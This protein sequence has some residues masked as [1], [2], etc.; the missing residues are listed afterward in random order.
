MVCVPPGY[1]LDEIWVYQTGL[2]DTTF[3]VYGA[4]NART[5]TM[6]ASN[7]TVMAT[8]KHQGRDAAMP[9]LIENA[10]YVV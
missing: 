6:S 3:T 9:L 4:G 8:F 1:E 10:R 7:V 5:F 2:P